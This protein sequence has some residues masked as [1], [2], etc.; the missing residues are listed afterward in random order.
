M[1]VYQALIGR[2]SLDK[3][4]VTIAGDMND[5]YEGLVAIQHALLDPS[6]S[7][8]ERYKAVEE[9]CQLH[10]RD[11]LRSLTREANRQRKRAHRTAT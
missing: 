10:L 8:R 5:L 6:L 4:A 1:S 9:E 7:E 3:V 11:H 2:D